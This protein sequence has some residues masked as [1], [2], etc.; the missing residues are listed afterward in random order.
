MTL[1]PDVIVFLAELWLR[2]NELLEER[3]TVRVR[4]EDG[5][6]AFCRAAGAGCAAPSAA[7]SDGGTR[8]DVKAQLFADVAYGALRKV[9]SPRIT[10]ASS[11]DWPAEP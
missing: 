1:P 11:C 3:A 5:L 8:T 4:R 7:A 10:S 6:P 2:W 9:R